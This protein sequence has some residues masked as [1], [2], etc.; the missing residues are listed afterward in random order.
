MWWKGGFL[1]VIYSWESASK[2][3]YSIKCLSQVSKRELLSDL[4]IEVFWP[5]GIK[6]FDLWVSL[7]KIS[8]LANDVVKAGVNTLILTEIYLFYVIVMQ[9]SLNTF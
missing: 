3:K 7:A 2:S 6:S 1:L 9:R 5:L 4:W 8:L